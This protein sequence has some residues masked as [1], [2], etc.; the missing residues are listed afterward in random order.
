MGRTMG[1]RDPRSGRNLFSANYFRY[2]QKG[3]DQ[4]L[5]ALPRKVA[6]DLGMRRGSRRVVGYPEYMRVDRALEEHWIYVGLWLAVLGAF[7]RGE[8]GRSYM[9][10][11]GLHCAR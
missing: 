7:P 1:P 4:I 11:S 3:I 5:H 10:R 6:A 8:G 2:L 9:F